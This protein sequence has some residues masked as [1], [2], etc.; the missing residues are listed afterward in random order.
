MASFDNSLYTII[1]GEEGYDGHF[2]TIV[3][4]RYKR[5]EEAVEMAKRLA[6]YHNKTI[7]IYH[8]EEVCE[9]DATGKVVWWTR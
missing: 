1:H 7:R 6:R 8:Y 3:E 9:V 2:Q 4:G 5:E